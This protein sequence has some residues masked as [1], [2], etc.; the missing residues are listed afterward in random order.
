MIAERDYRDLDLVIKTTADA[1]KRAFDAGYEQGYK[2][3][4]S[5]GY[6]EAADDMSDDPLGY[7]PYQE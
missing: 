1:L 7:N 6:N 5:I 2:V 3:G 4:Y